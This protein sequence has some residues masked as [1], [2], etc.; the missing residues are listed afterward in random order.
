MTQMDI[1]LTHLAILLPA[2]SDA[3]EDGTCG[4]YFVK[5]FLIPSWKCQL[6]RREMEGP[7]GLCNTHWITTHSCPSSKEKKNALRLPL[8]NELKM[9]RISPSASI[10][11]AKDLKSSDEWCWENTKYRRR[12]AMRSKEISLL[13]WWCA[14]VFHENPKR[15]VK[16]P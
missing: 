13:R 5:R 15:E 10:V 3:N 12:C 4:R 16:D 1:D 14:L 6:E 2:C 11:V 8:K 7:K 9:L